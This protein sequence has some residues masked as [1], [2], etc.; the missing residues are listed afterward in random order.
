MSAGFTPRRICRHNRQCTGIGAGSSVRRTS[1]LSR[2]R[3]PQT[4]AVSA[5]ARP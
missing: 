4:R 5:V 2:E 1:D 3:A